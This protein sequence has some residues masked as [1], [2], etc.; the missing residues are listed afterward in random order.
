MAN[1]FD[2]ILKDPKKVEILTIAFVSAG[3]IYLGLGIYYLLFYPTPT[4]TPSALGLTIL[5]IG[6]TLIFGI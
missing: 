2:L 3:L 5:G 1:L 6:I 4:E